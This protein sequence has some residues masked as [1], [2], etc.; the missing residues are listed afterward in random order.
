MRLSHPRTYVL[1]CSLLIASGC[2]IT[3]GDGNFDASFFRDGEDSGP[4]RKPDA[5]RDAGV[6]PDEDSGE[7]TDAAS[8]AAQPVG[9]AAMDSAVQTPADLKPSDAPKEFAR[10]VC[11]AFTDCLGPAL[12]LEL[13]N[14]NPCEDF[15]TRQQ[16]DR[17]LHFLEASINAGR[18]AFH[19]EL[20]ASCEKDLTSQGCSVQTTRLPA[21]CRQAIEGKVA[22]DGRCNINYD[23]EGK[24]FCDKGLDGLSCPGTCRP[25]QTEGMRCLDA[26]AECADGLSC[27]GGLCVAPLSEG[28]SCAS[29][30][31]PAGLTCQGQNAARTCRSIASVYA[32]KRNDSCDPFAGKLCQFDLVCESQS[33]S[34]GLCKP[35][36]ARSGSCRRATPNQCPTDQYCKNSD[37]T[38]ATQPN[39]G[40]A[41]VCAN[42]PVDTQACGITSLCAPGE[43]C[44]NSDSQCHAYKALT[45][46][47][48]ERAEC[49]SGACEQNR[50]VAPLDCS[51]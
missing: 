49:Y 10:G 47:C 25:L 33:A 20:F 42:L 3:A 4:S 36:A 31:C 27:H 46:S 15:L 21:S 43:V 28:D 34:S 48:V 29:A 16:S 6:A 12:V 24:A 9:D 5:G 7:A 17:D 44:L 32:G 13:F 51:M 18:A 23:C 39:P 1:A 26:S 19:P 30:P 45:E 50:C 22:L 35:P 40:V 11:A 37:P 41:G 14:R 38:K 2:T 8:D